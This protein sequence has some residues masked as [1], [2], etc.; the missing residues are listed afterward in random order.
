[1]SC[2]SVQDMIELEPTYQYMTFMTPLSQA[3]ADRLIG[4]VSSGLGDGVVVDAGCGW[5]ELLLQVLAATPAARGRR[6]RS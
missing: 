4:F 3:K 2:G 6:D 5:A 1:M